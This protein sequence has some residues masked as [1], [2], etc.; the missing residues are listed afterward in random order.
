MVII[1]HAHSP[2]YIHTHSYQYEHLQKTELVDFTT[3]SMRTPP[4]AEPD[5]EI[6]QRGAAKHTSMLI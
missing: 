4:R 1:Q 2:L 6:L 5:L 3:L